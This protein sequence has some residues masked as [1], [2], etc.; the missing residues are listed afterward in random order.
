MTAFWR[1]L[2]ALLVDLFEKAFA[3]HPA[4][5]PPA[6]PAAPAI[7]AIPIGVATD[8]LVALEKICFAGRQAIVA[9]GG[10][11]QADANLSLAVLDLAAQYIPAAAELDAAAHVAAVLIPILI[12]LRRADNGDGTAPNHDALGPHHGRG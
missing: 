2:M 8:G 5:P 6:T 11:L 4:A 10:D 12:A 7:P 1:A 3:A 9:K